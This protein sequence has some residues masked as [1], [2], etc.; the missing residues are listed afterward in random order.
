MN[1]VSEVAEH[2]TWSLNINK[3]NLLGT[4]AAGVRVSPTPITTLFPNGY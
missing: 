2:F 4:G 3:N 1:Q